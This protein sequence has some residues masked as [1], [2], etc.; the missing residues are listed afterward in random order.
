MGCETA[1]GAFATED[2]S[3]TTLPAEPFLTPCTGGKGGGRLGPTP[4]A[5]DTGGWE[6]P[7]GTGGLSAILRPWVNAKKGHVEVRRSTSSNQLALRP[8][9]VDKP[10]QGYANQQSRFA[11]SGRGAKGYVFDKN[12][13]VE[14]GAGQ[15]F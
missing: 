4:L 13:V 5:E 1:G 2:S 6:V 7:L 8:S 9:P 3:T 10:R 11:T 15:T 14:H 12:R